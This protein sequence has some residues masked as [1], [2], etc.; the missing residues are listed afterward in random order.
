MILRG[1]TQGGVSLFEKGVTLSIWLVSKS[2][3]FRNTC[4]L[5]SMDQVTMEV[6]K[7]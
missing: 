6:V 1:K 4:E 3:I 5:S 2:Y 7:R